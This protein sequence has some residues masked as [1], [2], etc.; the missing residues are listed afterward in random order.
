MRTP[1]IRTAL[2]D[3]NFLSVFNDLP[4]PPDNY[5]AHYPLKATYENVPQGYIKYAYRTA[6]GSFNNPLVPTLGQANSPYAR[7]VPPANIA[8]KRALPDPGLVFDSLLKRDKFEEHPGGISSLFFAFADLI[9]HSIFYTDHSDWTKNKTSSYL[10]LSILYGNNQ[11]QQNGVRKK[12]GSGKLHDDVF[13]D[14]RLLMMPPATCALLVLFN[15]NHNVCFFRNYLFHSLI[16]CFQYIAQRLLD[17]NENGN[18]KVVPSAEKKM[19]QDDE[20]FHRSRL[21]NCGYFM[22][23]ILGGTSDLSDFLIISN[24][25]LSRLRWCHSWTR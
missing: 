2:T 7:S 8:P 20:I 18:F 24:H 9:I 25:F 19:L 10:D 5:L 12:D 14:A 11:A 15:R 6:D 17:I 23:I 3:P 1:G 22:K 16:S 13:A 21:V 4:H